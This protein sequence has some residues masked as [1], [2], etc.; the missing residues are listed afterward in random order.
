MNRPEAFCSLC[1][2][3]PDKVVV[4]E[5]PETLGKTVTVCCH[6]EKWTQELSALDVQN[7]GSSPVMIVVPPKPVLE[8]A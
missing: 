6:G 2:R 4:V 8:L 3:Y 1:N 7:L 5:S